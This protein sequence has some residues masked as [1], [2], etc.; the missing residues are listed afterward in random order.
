MLLV[1]VSSGAQSTI[2]VLTT[3]GQVEYLPADSSTPERIGPLAERPAT[4]TIRLSENARANLAYGEQTFTLDQPGSYDL[5]KL[6]GQSAPA[7]NSGFFN[8]LL[9]FISNG[10]RSTDDEE[11]IIKHREEHLANIGGGVEGFG[12]KKAGIALLRI[13]HGHLSDA[14]VRFQWRHTGQN[15]PYHFRIFNEIEGTEVFSSVLTDTV[16]TL[17]PDWIN[18]VE[19]SAYRWYISQPEKSDEGTKTLGNGAPFVYDPVGKTKRLERLRTMPDYQNASPLEQALMTAQLLENSSFFYD[20]ENVY[21]QLLAEKTEE[22]LVR[23]LYAAFLARQGTLE[24]AQSVL[25]RS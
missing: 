11:K 20:A 24:Q 16:F 8:R 21:R 22:E 23:R 1:A 9:V 25:S 7:N 4:G 2:R 13:T 10:I 15:R 3:S 18:L 12:E 17:R 5:K 19:K 14:A 6:V